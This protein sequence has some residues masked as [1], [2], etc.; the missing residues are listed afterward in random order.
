MCGR[1]TLHTEKELL[2]ERFEVSLDGVESLAPRYNIAPAQT[3][4]TVHMEDNTA[5][6]EMMHW[7]L[8]PAWAKDRSKL[9]KMINARIETAASKPSYR[10]SFRRQR[11]LIL[12]DGFYEWQAPAL[13]TQGKTPYWISLE[14]GQPFAMAGLWAEW[15]PPNE[16]DAEPLRSCSILTTQANPLLAS[17]H[18]RMPVILRPEAEKPWLDPALDGQ[19]E[20]LSALLEPI[21]PKA[22]RSS[23]VSKRVNSTRNNGPELIQPSDDPSLGFT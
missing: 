16:P 15:R 13:P 5:R 11:C 12:A 23:A 3:I 20:A 8:V 9:P 10:S 2:A 18:E 7:G 17:I 14:A 19:A 1:F 4:L 6:A 22:F 21:P